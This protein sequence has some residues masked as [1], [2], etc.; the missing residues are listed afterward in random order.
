MSRPTEYQ[1]V[2][3]STNYDA[4]P[5]KFARWLRFDG[6]DD[7]LNLP[8]M[9]LYA[10]GSASVV[11]AMSSFTAGGPS[12]IIAERNKTDTAPVYVLLGKASAS[13]LTGVY[14]R[15]NSN[16]V[17]LNSISAAVGDI[18]SPATIKTITDNG[19]V[20]KKHVNAILADADTYT[21]SGTLTLNSTT[22]AASNST[23][24]T[25]FLLGNLYS[26]I[27]TKS[28]LSDAQR[29]ACERYAASKAGVQL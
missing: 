17:V 10:G 4:D 13:I 21:R 12:D 24:P 28:A 19:S 23:A 11:V 25:S 18:T 22:I 6:V 5:A 29:I 2:I 8:Y 9:G 16:Y 3:T 20:V 15:N 1:W 26:L 14:I 27:I 7:Y